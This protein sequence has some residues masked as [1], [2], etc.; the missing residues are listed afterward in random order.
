MKGKKYL[1]KIYDEGD[2]KRENGRKEI[3][4]RKEKMEDIKYL[5][6]RIKRRNNL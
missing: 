5:M 6:K 3:F 4:E 1:M 2:E